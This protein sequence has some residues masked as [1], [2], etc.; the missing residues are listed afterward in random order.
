M[1]C[2]G[3]ESR[4][5]G[6]SVA[7]DSPPDGA[8]PAPGS[9]PMPSFIRVSLSLPPAIPLYLV[10]LIALHFGCLHRS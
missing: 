10:I 3:A 9:L 5:N 2:A 1:L 7:G 4:T 8:P 6:N